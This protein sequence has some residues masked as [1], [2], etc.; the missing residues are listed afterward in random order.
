MTD[1]SLVDQIIQ[2]R[3]GFA[4]SGRSLAQQIAPIY[5]VGLQICRRESASPE[6]DVFARRYALVEVHATVGLDWTDLHRGSSQI[7]AS[8]EIAR[9]RL[10]K[11][12]Y[13]CHGRSYQSNFTISSA[14]D[15]QAPKPRSGI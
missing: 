13:L 5:R 7:T 14:T 4:L 10:L 12:M 9:R 15:A 8:A 6:T 11:A 1:P 3:V 2:L